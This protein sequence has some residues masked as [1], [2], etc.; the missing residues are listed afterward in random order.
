MDIIL[1]KNLAYLVGNLKPCGR[2][3]SWRDVQNALTKAQWDES[4]KWLKYKNK[5][6]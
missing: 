2:I 4:V 3:L 1:Y 6:I 5:L